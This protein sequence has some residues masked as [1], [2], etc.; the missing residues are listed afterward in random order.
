MSAENSFLKKYLTAGKPLKETNKRAATLI[1]FLLIPMSG[2]ITDMYIPSMPHMA[3]E[4]HQSENAIQLTLTLF[5]VSYGLAQFLTGN[6]IDSFGRYR[7][8]L[9]SLVIFILSNLIIV[10]TN[11]IIVIDLMRILQGISTGFIVV[12]KRAF[13]V[14]VFEGAKRKHYLSLM[15]I[16]WSA[17]PVLAPFA[18]GY[19]QHYFN[20]Q[21]NFYVLAGY[22]FFML[23]LEWIFS[24][25][26]IAGFRPLKIKA[27]LKDYQFMF[28]DRLFVAGLVIC[29][30]SY[31]TTML[32]GLSG[33]FIIEH[34][35]HF[36]PVIAGYGALAMG[37]AW[38]LGGFIGKATIDK[39]FLP[40][41]RLTNAV[42]LTLA[43]IMVLAALSFSNI[44]TLIVFAFLIHMCVGFIFNNYFA[45]CL[46]R[47]P[48]LAGVVSGL[49]GGTTFIITAFSSYAV[50]GLI[51]PDTQNSLGLAYLLMGIAILPILQFILKP[52]IAKLA[53]A[54]AK[55]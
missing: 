8:T 14:D 24:G 52:Y 28:R 53:A 7:L 47:F 6:L 23:L 33:S 20:W 5:L 4:M 44:Y 18:G 40:K 32:F 42:Q 29:G 12:A 38:M 26:T 55:S 54:T 50:V 3:M 36:S 16:V 43:L 37:L 30:L 2:L 31:G 22:G 46:G 49:S 45:L 1:A 15:S 51:K 19:L 39:P 25:E 9:W 41:L 35:M 10:A 11:N 48:Q 17:A 34:Q 27:I 21:S 13:F